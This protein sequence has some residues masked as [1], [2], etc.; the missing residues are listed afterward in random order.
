MLQAQQGKVKAEKK[1]KK[2]K[3]ESDQCSWLADPLSAKRL[4]GALVRHE[5]VFPLLWWLWVRNRFPP[6]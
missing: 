3:D 4:L 6:G 1:K 2:Q 5:G